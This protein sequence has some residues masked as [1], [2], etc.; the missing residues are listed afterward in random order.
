MAFDGSRRHVWQIEQFSY[1]PALLLVIQKT[2]LQP[3]RLLPRIRHRL[4]SYV[5]R[6]HQFEA[7]P[8]MA[9]QP[10]MDDDDDCRPGIAPSSPSVVRCGQ[11][12]YVAIGLELRRLNSM[13]LRNS[14]CRSGR[15]LGNSRMM[16]H[17]DIC[18]NRVADKHAPLCVV[19]PSYATL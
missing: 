13:I 7:Q 6:R 16:L 14:Y 2:P 11:F 19:K 5:I 18:T 4:S 15:G 1:I 12:S 8:P 17:Y 3:P 9:T 10:C